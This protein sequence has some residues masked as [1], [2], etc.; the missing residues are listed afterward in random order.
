MMAAAAVG[1]VKTEGLFISGTGRFRGFHGTI[2]E[3]AHVVQQGTALLS[4][5]ILFSTGTRPIF[6][7]NNSKF[8]RAE[9]YLAISSKIIH[10]NS[11]PTIGSSLAGIADPPSQHPVRNRGPGGVGSQREDLREPPQVPKTSQNQHRGGKTENPTEVYRR[12][13]KESCTINNKWAAK[14]SKIKGFLF[15]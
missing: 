6:N 4:N 15:F 1:V 12:K 3:P 13:M 2:V 5:K 7:I 10:F 11:D 9:P 8:Q 14:Y